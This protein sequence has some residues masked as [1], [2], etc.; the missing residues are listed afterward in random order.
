[1]TPDVQATWQ[2]GAVWARIGAGEEEEV[3]GAGS[4]SC[5]R[6]VS[7]ALFGRRSKPLWKSQ[8]DTKCLLAEVLCFLQSFPINF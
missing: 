3:R 4:R 2:H 8:M 7:Q 6:Q 1:M 5:R